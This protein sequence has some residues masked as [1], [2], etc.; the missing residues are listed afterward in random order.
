MNTYQ[1]QPEL[2]FYKPLQKDSAGA[3]LQFKYSFKNK[4]VFLEAAKQ[5]G[6]KLEIGHK[7]QFDWEGK[8]IFKLGEVDIGRILMT[9]ARGV[10]TSLLHATERD[11]V[12][13]TTA[14]KVVKQTGQYDNYGLQ[15]STKIGSNDPVRVNMYLD[16]HE[17]VLLAQFLRSSLERAWGF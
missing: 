11:G 16:H 6:P 2:R 1:P 9:A 10:E 14:M 3:A 13:R 12:K 7:D 15:I 17:M 5:K 4:S 8:I